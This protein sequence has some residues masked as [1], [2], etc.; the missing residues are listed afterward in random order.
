METLQKKLENEICEN[1]SRSVVV[2][3]QV[4]QTFQTQQLIHCM[5]TGY[6][7]SALSE[8][9]HSGNIMHEHSYTQSNIT[10]HH[11]V[12]ILSEHIPQCNIIS[13]HLTEPMHTSMATKRNTLQQQRDNGKSI[14]M[15][16][17]SSMSAL[18]C[19]RTQT[20][21]VVTDAAATAEALSRDLTRG[22]IRVHRDS[23]AQ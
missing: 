2:W 7:C 14:S 20:P 10:I 22:M 23:P 11:N 5:T 3:S 21:V 13:S 15:A 18:A 16:K 1:N 6:R 4:S 19:R 12:K 17:C 9:S 8:G